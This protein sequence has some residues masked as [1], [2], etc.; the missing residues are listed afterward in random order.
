MR[1]PA[2]TT[3]HKRGAPNRKTKQ[4]IEAIDASGL[5]PLDYMLAV[6]RDPGA[7][8][9]RR[10]EMARAA[11]AYTHPR[12]APIAADVTRLVG[13]LLAE[14]AESNAPPEKRSA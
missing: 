10:D 1:K 8:P 6:M 13:Q 5:T 7:K 11:A 14:I 12:L 2:T 4:K 3:R 9:E